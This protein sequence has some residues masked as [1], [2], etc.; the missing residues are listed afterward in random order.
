MI[1]IDRLE[2]DKAI[3]EM[4][5]GSI[6]EISVY[7]LPAEAH[8]GSLLIETNGYYQ[9]DTRTEAERRKRLSSRT[10]QIFSRKR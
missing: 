1:K 10:R 2:G 8:E 5:D 4:D 3:L 9:L 7:E 6:R